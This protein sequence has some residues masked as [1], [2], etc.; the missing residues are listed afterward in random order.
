[1]ETSTDGVFHVELLV[2]EALKRGVGELICLSLAL[3]FIGKHHSTWRKVNSLSLP[4]P[5]R[6]FRL[7][8]QTSSALHIASNSA[9]LSSHRHFSVAFKTRDLPAAFIVELQPKESFS[10]QSAK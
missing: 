2:G 3:L 6:F 9:L 10:C 7:G 1:M 8:F 4:Q 5:D